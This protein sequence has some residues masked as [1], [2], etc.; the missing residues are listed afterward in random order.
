MLCDLQVRNLAV[1]EK[2]EIRFGTGL[3]IL[4]GE[5][6][7]GKSILVDALSLLGGSRANVDWIRTGAESLS[8]VGVFRPPGEAWRGL[9]TEAGLD[10]EGDELVVRREVS[11]GGRNRIFLD[12]QPVT[13]KLL[14]RMAPFLLRIH[15]QGEEI[16]LIAP[17]LQRHWLDQMGG[18]DG[19][20]LRQQVAAAYDAYRSVAERLE[21]LDSGQR[22]R[23]ERLDLLRF[24]AQEIDSAALVVGEEVEL[25]A[26]RDLLQNSETFG[27]CLGGS[28]DHLVDA[29]GAVG[30][31]L[32][33][34]QR[35]LAELER[36]EPEAQGW[37]TEL[38]ELAIRGAELAETLRQR[39]GSIDADSGRL[40]QIEDRLAI[41]ERLLRKYGATSEE[42]VARRSEIAEALEE[43]GGGELRRD[44]LQ[45]QAEEL[46]A[47]Y[48]AKAQELSATRAGWGQELSREIEG[49]FQDLALAKASFGVRIESRTDSAS[50]LQVQGRPIAFGAQ[51]VDQVTFEFVAN[52]GEEPRPLA[53]VASGGELSR[54]YLALQ[55]AVRQDGGPTT[56]VFDEVDA[57]VGGAQAAILGRKLRRLAKREQLLA[58][59]HL[60]Q[61][62]SCAHQHFRV[63]KRV[64][65][66]R[67][68]V[69]VTRLE[70]NQ[71][72]EEVAR[73]LAGAEVT[74][75]SRSHAQELIAGAL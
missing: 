26:E 73:M 2:A 67:T 69:Q 22:V 70:E 9:L 52:P 72:V 18:V 15:G 75:L 41:L 21:R 14:S 49:Q 53:K 62:A 66:G 51:G 57:G 58:V 27:R 17:E 61:V 65:K 35:L 3:N 37:Q 25:R 24:Q 40:N 38:S 71:R 13:L 7:A 10:A 28:V 8:V 44:E 42:V 50:P 54:V 12:D 11:R 55:L 68:Q 59:T 64:S 63:S 36:W 74:E 4:T 39:L 56:L 47:S 1:L 43:L 6:G 23:Q 5:T 32:A 20:V 16:G 31:R 19:D 34:A 45:G 30:E 46:L 48:R 33:Q 60:P 29:D